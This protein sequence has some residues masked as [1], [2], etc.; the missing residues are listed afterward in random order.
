[1]I[2]HLQVAIATTA[3]TSPDLVDS[4]TKKVLKFYGFWQVNPPR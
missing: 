3:W 1:M 4:L 2:P